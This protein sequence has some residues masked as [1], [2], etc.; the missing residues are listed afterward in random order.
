[1]TYLVLGGTG[2]VGAALLEQLR[3]GGLPATAV[4]APR[5]LADPA[6]GVGRLAEIARQHPALAELRVAMTGCSVVVN[7]AGAATPGATWNAGLVGANALMPGVVLV[8]AQ[9]AGVRRVV[10]LS[11][12][13]VQGRS[14]VL[15]ESAEVSPFSAYSR[16]K[17]MGERVAR[18]LAV[19]DDTELVVLRATSVQ[20]PGRSTT[21]S[22]Q[23]IARSRL[24][25][26]AADGTQP[27]A[28]SS[29]DALCEF[30]VAVAGR[31]EPV[32]GIVLQ[33]WEGFSVTDVLRGAGGRAPTVLP[34]WLCRATIGAGHAAAALTGGRL[35]GS[36][37]RVEAMWFGQRVEAGWA[38]HA[39]VYPRSNLAAV[40]AGSPGGQLAGTG[41][42]NAPTPSGTPR[43][44][45]NGP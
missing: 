16:S 34:R 14:P 44:T 37:R 1:M 10:H 23:R 31:A 26:V 2:F 42:G 36:V 39:G 32:P 15:T 20:G 28:V 11:S 5:L 7:A 9:Q 18:L 12:A 6:A 19:D 17:A 3:V 40:L 27:A 13:A 22:L 24:A 45:V 38:V 21:A 29:V 4:A 25:S 41:P 43:S 8:A 33:P 35:A 30:I